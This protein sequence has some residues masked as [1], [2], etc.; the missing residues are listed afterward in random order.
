LEVTTGLVK[1]A[2]YQRR[3][4]REFPDFNQ[5]AAPFGWKKAVIFSSRPT[6]KY[7]NLR[8]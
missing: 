3:R 7:S 1:T 6:S 2:H 8:N 4:R 5:N